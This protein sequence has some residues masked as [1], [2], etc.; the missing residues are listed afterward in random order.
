MKEVIVEHE[1]NMQV[2]RRVTQFEGDLDALRAAIFAIYQEMLV[3]EIVKVSGES[4][5]DI[6]DPKTQ[7]EILERYLHVELHNKKFKAFVDVLD[8]ADVKDGDTLRASVPVS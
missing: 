8:A 3:Q 2:H 4:V 6:R 7:K 5:E 1:H